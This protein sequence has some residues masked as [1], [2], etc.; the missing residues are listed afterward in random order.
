MGVGCVDFSYR[1]IVCGARRLR[2]LEWALDVEPIDL[3]AGK[4]VAAARRRVRN[5]LRRVGRPFLLDRQ[6]V[7]EIMPKCQS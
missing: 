3:G 4:G 7:C 2:A 6:S 1:R 5:Y